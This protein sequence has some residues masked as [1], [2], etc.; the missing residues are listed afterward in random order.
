MERDRRRAVAAAA[1]AL[2]FCV[3]LT[4]MASAHPNAGGGHDSDDPRL[5]GRAVLP[6][7]TFAGPPPAGA[8]G[9]TSANGI[10][11]PLPEQPV[12]GFSAVVEGR[13]RGEYLAMADNGFGT[14]T[15][16]RDFLIRAYYLRPDFKTARDGSGTVRVGDHISFRDPY[17]R[18][19]FPIVNEQTGQRLLTGGDIDPESLQRD[20][21]GDL[22]VGD[23]FGPWLLHFDSQ[24]RLLD[25]PH[26]IPGVVAAT[27]PLSETQPVTL[28]N[29]RGFEGTAIS[30]NRLYGVLEGAVAGDPADARRVYE[31]DLR[32]KQLTER[33]WRYRVEQPGHLVAD[34]QALDRHQLAIIERDATSGLAAVDG[35]RRVYVV[36]LGRPDP[37][38]YLT[39]REVLDLS[40]IPDPHGVSLPAIHPGDIGIG[41]PF[42]VVCESVEALRT[43][44][45]ERVLVGCDNNIPNS[46]RNP[47]L[48]DDSEFI[49]VKVP[50]LGARCGRN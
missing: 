34:V 35:F 33:Q 43:A 2:A 44:G 9:V 24:G 23:E 20:R 29:S 1:A 38:G 21:R 30:R 27:N 45:D 14:K 37:D 10:T 49:V 7:E 47:G 26:G 50:A 8:V 18:I 19:G 4:G 17:R 5:I 16:S 36:E 11:F 28:A 32:G 46:A 48:A 39:K 25:P 42:S 3:T 40:A 6:V 12:V 22:W 31:F 41:D 13:W 15:N